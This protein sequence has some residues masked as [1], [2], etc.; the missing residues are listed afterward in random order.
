MSC[1]VKLL[2]AMVGQ[3]RDP[4]LTSRIM[5]AVRGRDT[6]PEILLRKHL[7]HRGLRYRTSTRL[8]GKPD[9]VFHKA[10]VV[11]F[12][13]G[14]F[15]HGNEWKLRGMASFDDQFQFRNGEFWRR[16]IM[17]N[18]ARDREVTKGLKQDGWTVIRVWASE[19][20]RDVERTAAK[21]ERAV[22]EAQA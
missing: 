12:V 4:A 17:G 16:K 20:L 1:H 2:T 15:W 18:V 11:A 22:R 21:V 9:I 7:W 5:S 3:P 13:D 14:D 8:L 19:V 6:R 10:R